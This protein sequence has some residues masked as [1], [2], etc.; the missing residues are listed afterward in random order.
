MNTA[1]LPAPIAHTDTLHAHVCRALVHA[2]SSLQELHKAMTSQANARERLL[3]RGQVGALVRQMAEL[4]D[5]ETALRMD[6]RQ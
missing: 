1:T 2:E 4:R 3:L 5:I 6:G